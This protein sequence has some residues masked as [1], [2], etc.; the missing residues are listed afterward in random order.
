MFIGSA[1]WTGN[2]WIGNQF[3]G[4][5]D[6]QYIAGRSEAEDAGKSH[7]RGAQ[8]R[9]AAGGRSWV[10]QRLLPRSGRLWTGNP[11]FLWV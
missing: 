9:A 6:V 5:L 3:T 11:L 4:V 10:S 7:E 1:S 8:P 2:S